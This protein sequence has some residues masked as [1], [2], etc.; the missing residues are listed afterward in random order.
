LQGI[1][2]GATEDVQVA[3]KG[4]E[5]LLKDGGDHSESLLPKFSRETI[6][7]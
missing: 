5:V 3:G 2:G 4:G 7:V 6:K 1:D